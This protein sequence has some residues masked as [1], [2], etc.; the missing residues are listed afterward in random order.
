MIRFDSVSIRYGVDQEPVIRDINLELAD[1]QLILVAGRTG[2]GKSTLLGAI[3]GHVPHFT[4]GIVTGRVEVEGLDTAQHPPRDL[5]HVI[6]VVN[7]NPLAGFVTDIVEEEL[8]YGMEQLGI[9]PQQM[10][11]RVEETL[12]ILGLADL[13]NRPLRTLSG[14]QQQRVAVGSVLATGVR[15][16]VLDEPTSA[17]DPVS[18]EEVLAALLRLV[19]DLGLTVIIAEHRLERVAGYA[20]QMLLLDG[21]GGVTQGETRLIM[22]ASSLVPPVVALGRIASFPEVP[23][24]V[25][26]AR[27]MADPIRAALVT[28]DPGRFRRVPPAQGRSSVRLADPSLK[29]SGTQR[30][31]AI[32]SD[33]LTTKNVRIMY[34]H[35]CAVN[36]VSLSL[37]PGKITVIMGRNG[38][39]KSS[40]LWA[41][42]G[43][44]KMDSGR[45]SVDGIDLENKGPDKVRDLVRLVPQT[46]CDLL[47]L[48]SVEEECQAADR[49]SGCESGLCRQ[50]LD[51]LAPQVDSRS[52]PRD[53][54]QGQ[55]LCLVLAIQLTARPHVILLDE[56]TR[57]L[58]YPAKASLAQILEEMAWEGRSVGVVTHDVEFAAEVA[59]QIIVMAAGE[60]IQSGTAPEVLGTS[61]LFAPQVAK[62]LYP[63]RWLTAY[64]VGQA[65]N[66]EDSHDDGVHDPRG[67][68]SEVSW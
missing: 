11:T 37:P 47:Y 58:D 5:A 68:E 28:K 63:E 14:G 41:L 4:G 2:S 29:P 42:T 60:V 16:L 56:P 67:Y 7:Q 54:S 48:S 27:R 46:A 36:N 30:L 17:L 23:L 34:G 53:L 13:R 20:D 22:E 19:H 32:E 66:L 6:G 25:R 8:A 3:N 9:D 40:L 10:R 18:S 15:V 26:D 61:A 59:D 43:V 12:D 51:A 24:S 52:H 62:V 1:G 35:T 50:I 33:G 38:S 39:G 57:G 21:R 44:Q 31:E 55:Q 64:Q 45:Y 49:E 65:L